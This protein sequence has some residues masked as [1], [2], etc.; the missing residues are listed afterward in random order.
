MLTHIRICIESD[1]GC[2]FL[3]RSYKFNRSKKVNANEPKTS[4]NRPE[5]TRDGP[6]VTGMEVIDRK[7]PKL[8]ISHQRWSGSHRKWSKVIDRKLTECNIPEISQ[9]FPEIDRKHQKLTVS[10][11]KSTA[12]DWKPT[13][14]Y[15]KSAGSPIK[16]YLLHFIFKNKDKT[17][18]LCIRWCFALP[19]PFTLVYQTEFFFYKIYQ[20]PLLFVSDA[21]SCH[22]IQFLKKY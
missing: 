7:L 9:K 17:C 5:V 13:R 15:W 18:I 16:L 8:T 1:G 22:N 10:H 12:I 11:R 21:W 20:K 3:P 2:S 6:E 19:F 4:G 14:S